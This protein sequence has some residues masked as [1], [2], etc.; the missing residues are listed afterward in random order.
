M[1]NDQY[2]KANYSR[3]YSISIDQNVPINLQSAP[4]VVPLGLANL[5]LDKRDTVEHPNKESQENS[6]GNRSEAAKVVDFMRNA[7]K[8]PAPSLIISVTGES[9]LFEDISPQIYM[10]FQQDLVSVAVTTSTNTIILYL[11]LI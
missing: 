8:L 1:N 10:L 4:P 9:A 7:W 3:R 6:S 2:E 11:F 5:W